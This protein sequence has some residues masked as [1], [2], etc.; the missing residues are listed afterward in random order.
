M[1]LSASLTGPFADAAELKGPLGQDVA[2]T[3]YAANPVETTSQEGG[4]PVSA[5]AI[6]ADAPPGLYDLT[7]VVESAGGKLIGEHVVRI[8]EGAT[9]MGRWL[10]PQRGREHVPTRGAASSP[11][12]S[13]A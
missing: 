1:T 2:S 7:T 9:F 13:S 5:I 8:E 6:P 3:T 4:V 12:A 10:L 11:S